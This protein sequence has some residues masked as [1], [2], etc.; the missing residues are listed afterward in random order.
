MSAQ[1]SAN[2]QAKK[3]GKKKKAPCLPSSGRCAHA[4]LGLSCYQ[5]IAGLQK[6]KSFL[7]DEDIFMSYEEEDTCM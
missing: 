2:A 1:L 7:E 4:Q 6:K 5:A 3:G